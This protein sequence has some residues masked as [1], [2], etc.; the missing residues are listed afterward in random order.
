MKYHQ[1][2]VSARATFAFGDTE[3]MYSFR[4]GASVHERV[5]DY[6]ELATGRRHTSQRDWSRFNLGLLLCALGLAALGAQASLMTPSLWSALWLT[7]GLAMLMLF[8]FSQGHFIVV[9]AGGAPVWI[10]DDK[11]SRQVIAEMDRRRHDRIADLYGTLNLA[12]EP[13]LEIRKIEWLVL[14]SVLTRDEADRQ[15]AIVEAVA[16]EKAKDR[17][18]SAAGARPAFFAREALAI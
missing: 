3:L 10:I 13:Y 16:A 14:E 2:R 4:Y 17:V 8:A 18:E 6:F 1:K 9:Q 15:I 5:I 7:P 11:A 12:N